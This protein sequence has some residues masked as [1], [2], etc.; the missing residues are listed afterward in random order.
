[1]D[2]V[3]ERPEGFTPE[4]LRAA[5]GQ[6]GHDLAVRAVGA[7]RI[8]TGQMGTTYRL[9]LQYEDGGEPGPPT[10]VA[11]VA[12]DDEAM[13]ALVAPGYAA[14][15][16]FY[17]HLAGDLDVRTPRCW[18]AAIT[19]DHTSFTLLLDDAAPA[20]PGVQADGCSVSLARAAIANLVGLHAPRWGDPA[21]RDL[22]F[23]MRPSEPMAAMLQDALVGATEAFVDRYRAVL[24]VADV[25]ILR[26]V[27]E[28]I[29]RWQLTRLE[30][31]AVVH[32]DYRLDNLLFPPSGD[33]V[34]AVDWQSVAVGP[35]LR[36]VAYFLGTSL[37]TDDRR[38]NEEALV[39]GYHD[40][41]VAC[42]VAGYD[43]DR[44]WED[45]RLGHLQG[46]MISILGCIYASGEQDERS[47]A[48]FLAMVRRS[49]AAIRDLGSLDLV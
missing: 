30:P 38:A 20:E 28:V 39:A 17:R 4:W 24:A 49:A 14:E 16:G 12:G 23:L 44:C 26:A 5:L 6:G 33:E 19:D 34:V 29:A 21:L 8:G 3:V 45:Y 13:R 43:A 27:A 1:V 11:K 32:G 42:G 7:E 9:S 40:A 22:D 46:P 36:D 35:P 2:E 48:M 31:S 15:V 18:Y 25:A 47:D 37:T 10:L 41:V